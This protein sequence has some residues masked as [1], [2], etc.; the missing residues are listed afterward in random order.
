[1]NDSYQEDSACPSTT[2]EK[3]CLK[4]ASDNDYCCFLSIVSTAHS[5][6]QGTSSYIK[7]LTQ[8]NSKSIIRE[9]MGYEFKGTILDDGEEGALNLACKDFKIE[10]E[11]SF[12]TFSDEEKEILKEEDH[13]FSLH[14]RTIYR[15]L[16][17]TEDLCK[18]GKL[19]KYASDAGL[20]CAYSELT[21]ITKNQEESIKTCFPIFK[22]DIDS[23]N[24]N[25]FT[26]D[27][28]NEIADE[29]EADSYKLSAIAEDEPIFTYDSKTAGKKSKS[30]MVNISKYF[31]LLFLLFF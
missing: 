31:M 2:N 13:C 30:D 5:E 18:N 4:A 24:L 1:M 29:Y 9:K 17:P 19:T 7:F 23:G 27:Y 20:K 11:Q 25:G 22:G 3:D 26:I 10:L 28:L 14:D 21:L 12:W 15:D 8:E 16:E 6:C